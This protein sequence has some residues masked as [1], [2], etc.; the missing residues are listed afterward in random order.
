MKGWFT[1]RDFESASSH[2]TVIR[3]VRYGYASDGAPSAVLSTPWYAAGNKKI[4]LSPRDHDALVTAYGPA[5]LNW[6]GKPVRIRRDMA[7]GTH[8]GA[9]VPALIVEPCDPQLITGAN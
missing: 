8:S 6:L 1:L 5:V 3:A 9:A 2:E 7:R 4:K